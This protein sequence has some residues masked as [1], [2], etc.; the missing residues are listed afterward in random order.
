[1]W[2]AQGKQREHA[3]PALSHEAPQGELDNLVARQRRFN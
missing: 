3:S 2:N 1:M